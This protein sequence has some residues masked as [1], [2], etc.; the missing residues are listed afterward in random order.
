MKMKW[1]GS[2]LY[3]CIIPNGMNIDREREKKLVD[4]VGDEE[5]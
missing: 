3:V 4:D 5:K 1:N 2:I